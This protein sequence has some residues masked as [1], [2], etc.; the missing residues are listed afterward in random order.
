MTAFTHTS[1]YSPTHS[2]SSRSDRPVRTTLRLAALELKLLAREPIVAVS[3]IGF[4]LVTVLVLAGVF[5]QAP[6][7]DFGGVAPSD[8]YIA[9]YIGVVLASMGL[10]TIPGH[11]ATERELGVRRR[12]RASGVSSVSIVAREIVLGVVLGTISVAVVVAAGAA[13][14]G[15]QMPDDPLGVAGWFIA[16]LVCFIAIGVA[17]GT[18]VPTGRSAA[19]LGNFVFVPMFLLGGG[20]PPR[21]VMTSTMHGIGD[22]L[23]L[24]HVVGGIRQSWLGTTDD[25]HSLWYPLLVA[26][27]A[28][29]LAV[30]VGQRRA[31]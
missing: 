26:A 6:D 8:H 10:I 25:P 1:T 7:P 22:A 31:V 21:A 12:L 11:V 28:V 18:M 30:R 4:P 9:G 17:L 20:G 16:G 23:P 3:L 27:V 13:V 19:A 14:Y 15:L 5:G 24:S 29:L 2:S